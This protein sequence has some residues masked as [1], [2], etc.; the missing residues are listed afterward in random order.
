MTIDPDILPSL[1]LLQ[2]YN[3]HDFIFYEGDQCRFYHQIL[4]GTVKMW[5]LY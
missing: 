4:D 3:K 5:Q 1:V 2:K